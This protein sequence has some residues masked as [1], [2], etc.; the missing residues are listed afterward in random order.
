MFT[1]GN[2]NNYFDPANG[3]VPS[4]GYLN[5]AGTTVTIFFA[6]GGSSDFRTLPTRISLNLARP[7]FTIEDV[8]AS[9]AGGSDNPFTMTFVDTAFADELPVL[10]QATDSFPNG[11][12]TDTLIGD[13]ITINWAGGPVNANDDYTSTFTFAGNSGAVHM[14][15]AWFRRHPSR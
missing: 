14:D 11:G 8:L 2:P 4:S 10:V 7:Q 1:G 3:Y 12:L 5:S 9:T 13:E 6:T 15:D